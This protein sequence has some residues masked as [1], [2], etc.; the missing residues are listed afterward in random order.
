M[1]PIFDKI[2]QQKQQNLPFVVYRK[3]NSKAIVGIFQENDHVYF[4]ENFEEKGFVFAPFQ[5][6][7]NILIPLE[8]SKVNFATFKK[9]EKINKQK[10]Y[11]IN[12]FEK[13]EF[14]SLVQNGVDEIHKGTFEKVV[15]SRTETLKFK[16]FKSKKIF[17]KLI[18]TY[19]TAFCYYWFHPK[20]GT[21]M[22]AT[23][24]KLLQAKENQVHT[25]SLAGT[26][27]FDDLKPSNW[28]KKEF[29]EQ[30][31]VTSYLVEKLK[32]I[33]SKV[34]V[35]KPYN[36]K[37]GNLIHLK[38]DIEA[39]L[40]KNQNLSDTLATLHP[41]PAV[42]GFPT[43]E[44]KQFI[45]ENESNDRRFYT[46]FLG[47]INHDFNTNDETTDL[48]VNLRCM[49]IKSPEKDEKT[50][51]IIFVG[52]GIT[53]DSSPELEWEETVNKTKTIKNIL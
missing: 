11:K 13:N 5:S 42:C 2:K 38:T 22:G 19:P 49:E 23:P 53:K 27:V 44:A 9:K 40:N 34:T 33:A 10:N 17:T 16:N 46:G 45:L 3:P 25:M 31:I 6:G 26:Q 36:A 35:S 20:I 50:K 43:E 8:V 29:N 47:E 14:M 41:T 15:L 37:A 39:Q 7:N 12:P 30:S 21:W 4:T 52:C 1:N 18:N 48:Y 32:K 28:T 24:E 51:V